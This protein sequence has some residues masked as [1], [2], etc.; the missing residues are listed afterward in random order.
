MK[1]PN[2]LRSSGEIEIDI[3]NCTS[4]EKRLYIQ[5]TA[6]D[7]AIAHTMQNIQAQLS[8]INGHFDPTRRDLELRQYNLESA[9]SNMSGDLFR[10]SKDDDSAT[11]AGYLV[12]RH[13]LDAIPTTATAVEK[14]DPLFAELAAAQ[15]FEAAAERVAADRRQLIRDELEARRAAAL[16]ELEREEEQQLA[17]VS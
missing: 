15:E 8:A 1:S 6:L 13:V 11:L 17:A 4:Q 16:A 14:L 3:N 5:S 2:K 10:R 12:L 9:I 7:H